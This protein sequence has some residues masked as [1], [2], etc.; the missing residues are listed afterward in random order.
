MVAIAATTS[1]LASP[2]RLA[3]WR[4]PCALRTLGE[5]NG[6]SWS[7]ARPRHPW[8]P[9]RAIARRSLRAG[10]AAQSAI[11]GGLPPIRANASL[12]FVQ[13]IARLGVAARAHRFARVL[14]IPYSP[15][16][17]RPALGFISIGM[18][19]RP[20]A[21]RLLRSASGPPRSLAAPCALRALGERN[22]IVEVASAT[23]P[24]MGAFPRFRAALARFES[25][26]L[27]QQKGPPG[28]GP[29]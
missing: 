16:T 23:A 11:H 27:Q 18:G 10:S 21:S 14:R 1:C 29:L 2:G 25:P 3:R 28:G 26:I 24:S 13:M 17:V 7:L 8:A 20:P 19:I 9:S 12:N 22:G 5:R 15:A 4:R 6:L